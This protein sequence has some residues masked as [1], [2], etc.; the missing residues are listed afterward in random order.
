MKLKYQIYLLLK[1]EEKQKDLKI[2]NN[3]KDYYYGMVQKYLILWVF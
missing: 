2:I 3:I 1:E